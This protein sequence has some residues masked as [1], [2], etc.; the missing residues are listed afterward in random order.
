MTEIAIDAIKNDGVLLGRGR[1]CYWNPGNVKFRNMIRSY[2]DKYVIDATR[3]YKS[4]IV[5]ALIKT[6]QENGIRFLVRSKQDGNWYQAQPYVV[7]LKVS[8]ALRDAR[9]SLALSMKNK[10]TTSCSDPKQSW[11]QSA[12]EDSTADTSRLSDSPKTP[13]AIHAQ[14]SLI[15]NQ[16]ISP[17]TDTHNHKRLDKVKSYDSTIESI[18]HSSDFCQSRHQ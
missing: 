4:N 5:Q 11:K 12:R 2:V 16:K 6:A 13:T 14:A 8:H 17:L 15:G 18:Q 9:N 10:K 3:S 1:F 7:Q